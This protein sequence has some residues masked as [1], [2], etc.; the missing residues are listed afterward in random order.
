MP[1][2]P[3]MYA[4]A[5]GGSA[6]CTASVSAR[7]SS[8]RPTKAPCAASD[9][10]SESVRAMAHL[11]IPRDLRILYPIP[12][13]GRTKSLV[14]QKG[15]CPVGATTAGALMGLSLWSREGLE[16]FGGWVQPRLA[17]SRC[18]PL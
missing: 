9:S 10:R 6:A 12:R 17:E 2:G 14:V 5:N 8:S 15:S 3:W 7:S 13:V 4:T 11:L 18:D 16:P 1:P